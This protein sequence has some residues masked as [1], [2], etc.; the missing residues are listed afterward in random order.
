MIL[1]AAGNYKQSCIDYLYQNSGLHRG[2]KKVGK[3][4]VD[5]MSVLGIARNTHVNLESNLL[6]V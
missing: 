6:V 2:M 1:L 5:W 3:E 4:Y